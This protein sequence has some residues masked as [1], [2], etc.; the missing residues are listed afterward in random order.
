MARKPAVRQS[1]Q[2]AE[3][4]VHGLCEETVKGES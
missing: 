2:T 4:D 1:E 3:V